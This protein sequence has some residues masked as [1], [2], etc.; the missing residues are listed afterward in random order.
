MA[1]IYPYT[2]NGVSRIGND[3][4]DKSQKTIMNT[5]FNNYMLSSYFSEN[6]SS[7]HVQFA[8]SQPSMM[9][10]GSNGSSSGG[11]NALTVDVDSKL[12]V[13]KESGRALEKLS[14][15]QRPFLTVPYL[16]R[17][18]CDTV[19]ESQ[20]KQGDIITNKKSV[21]TITEQSFANKQMYPLIDSIKD[22][23]TNPKYLVQ[24][25]ALDGWVRGGSATRTHLPNN[26]GY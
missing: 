12:N 2:F 6:H 23:I 13:H 19:L 17:G 21:S 8:T 14:L 9:F 26:S 1:S 11:I 18:S 22:T 5:R 3:N 4:T 20:L 15:Q 16:G 24:E 25:A 7:D 10:N